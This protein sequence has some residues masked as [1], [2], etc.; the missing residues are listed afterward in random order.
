MSRY[1]LIPDGIDRTNARVL[2]CGLALT[3]AASCGHA[4]GDLVA[5][6]RI[7]PETECVQELVTLNIK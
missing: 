4:L 7:L 1:D 6:G 3:P 2:E 5:R